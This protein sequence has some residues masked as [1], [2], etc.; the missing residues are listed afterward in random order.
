MARIIATVNQKGG[1]GKSTTAQI[2][3]DALTLR[4][5]RVLFVDLDAQGNLTYALGAQQAELTAYEALTGTHNA[6]QAIT[7]TVQGDI[8]PAS[9]KLAA[10]DIKLSGKAG[11]AYALS[12]ALEP[13]Q[14]RYSYIIIDTPPALGSTVINALTAADEVVIP[15]KAD[16]FSLQGLGALAQTLEAVLS[17]TNPE[18]QV[19]GILLQQFN[20]RTVLSQQIAGM[21]Q[22]VAAQ[23]NTTV[24][25]AT[26][27]DATAIREAQAL[28]EN[29][30]AYTKRQKVGQDIKVFIKELLG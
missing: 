4:G 21:V 7:P 15:T 20:P 3:G 9:P 28:Q 23:L 10:I 17:T 26:I 5:E 30:V 19:A 18:L 2:I 27:R 24:F 11:R 13:V 8:L 1:V 29:I 22:Q 14:Q 12:K 6:E 16:A 25:R